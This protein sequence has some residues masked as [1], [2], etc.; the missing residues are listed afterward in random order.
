MKIERISDTQMKF[1]LMHTDLEERDI[2]ISELSHSSDKTQRL[3]KEI[4]QLAQDEGAFT[5][6][7]AP[8]LIEA[9][10]V[11]VDSLAVMVTKIST[12]DLERFSLVPA[13]RERCRFKRDGYIHQ[14]E[15]PGEDS[16][17]VFSFED[18]EVA[19][20]AAGAINLL[21]YGQ[22]QLYKLNQRYYL[23]M[24]NETEDDRTTADLEAI[25]MEFGQKHVSSALSKQFMA[26]HGELI[27]ENAVAKLSA[28]ADM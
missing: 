22:S 17:C 8:L 3:F 10:R 25:L 12:E 20:S 24:L 21:F 18:L 19:A 28:Y 16:H 1:V 15:Y 4:M 27:F 9:M 6:E 13:A 23:W 5:S 2:K 26:E 11:G 14:P 7:A